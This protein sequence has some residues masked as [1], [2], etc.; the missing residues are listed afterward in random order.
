MCCLGNW[1]SY[2][3]GD[4]TAGVALSLAEASDV[5]KNWKEEYVYISSQKTV[6][7]FIFT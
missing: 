3:F 5:Q 1:F 2:T 6:Y 4:A 7:C